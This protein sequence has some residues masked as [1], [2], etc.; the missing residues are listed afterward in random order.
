[1]HR[2]FLNR[3]FMKIYFKYSNYRTVLVRLVNVISGL[4][5]WLAAKKKKVEV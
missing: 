1:M 2:D 5:G 4:A 3:W